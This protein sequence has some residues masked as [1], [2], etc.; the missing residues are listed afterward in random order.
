MADL[1][2]YKLPVG[3]AERRDLQP[4]DKVVFAVV[5][6]SIGDNGDCWPGVRT[7]AQDSGLSVPTVIESIRRLEASG[8]LT[9]ERRKRGKSSHYRIAQSAQET[10]A[11]KKKKCSRDFSSGAKGTCAQVLKGL[12]PNQTDTLNQTTEDTSF[13]FVLNSG[14]LWYL[15]QEKLDQYKGTF[16]N[17]DIE[18]ELRKAA[19]WLLDNPTQQKTARGMTRYVGGWLGRAKPEPNRGE[20]ICHDATEEEADALLDEVGR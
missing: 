20:L 6:D 15:P 11:V 8:L 7:I 17:L 16:P 12:K 9:A 4:S 13:A 1:Q 14:N 3:V 18:A 19:Q 2:F 5:Y 10:L